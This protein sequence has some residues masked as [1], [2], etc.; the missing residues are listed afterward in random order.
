MSVARTHSIV[1]SGRDP[2]WFLRSHRVPRRRRGPFNEIPAPPDLH[3]HRR[4]RHHNL[5]PTSRSLH[6][7]FDRD[8]PILRRLVAARKRRCHRPPLG[9]HRLGVVVRDRRAND[10]GM[11]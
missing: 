2:V 11:D 10:R 5:P 6:G 3:D 4:M 7:C 8:W 1:Y 9:G